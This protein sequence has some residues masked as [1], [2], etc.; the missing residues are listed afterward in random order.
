[1][2]STLIIGGSRFLGPK[3][4]EMLLDR[5]DEVT[6]FNRGNDY[7]QKLPL[8]VKRIAGDR[9]KLEEMQKVLKQEFDYIYDMCCYDKEDA[10]KVLRFASPNSHLI[11]LSTAAVYEKPS[12]YPMHED[13]ALG[14]WK[15]FGDYGTNK[16]AAELEYVK[17]SE[18][19]RSKVTIFRPVYLL[20]EDNYFDRENYYFSRIEH[21]VPILVPGNGNA[22]VQFAFLAETARAFVD[23]PPK[24]DDNV[25]IL[26]IGGN[27][28]ISLNNLVGMCA[29]ITGK[30]ADIVNFD[31]ALYELEEEAFYDDI[32]PFPNLNFIVSNDRIKSVYNTDFV[33]LGAGLREIYSQGKA[34]WRSNEVN[35]YPK[36]QQLLNK[37]RG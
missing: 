36:E 35:V 18:Q 9:T 33:P 13:S 15:S 28:Y 1:M 31:P 22:L 21:D 16:A 17:F 6:V 27:D 2:A 10:E 11:F 32:Y 12:V 23:V 4:I 3:I 19:H 37:I 29:S 20:G 8:T 7:G 34:A 14:A 30:D 5:G 24:Q 26:N 25:E